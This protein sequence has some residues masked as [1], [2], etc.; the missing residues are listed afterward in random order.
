MNR[1]YLILSASGPVSVPGMCDV[2]VMHGPDRLHVMKNLR[3]M[4][5]GLV[6]VRLVEVDEN[7]RQVGVA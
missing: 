5:I 1:R 3:A 6:G 2:L 4:G 7:D